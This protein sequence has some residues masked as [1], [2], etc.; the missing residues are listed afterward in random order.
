MFDSVEF[1]L[2]GRLYSYDT[3]HRKN[4]QWSNINQLT[5]KKIGRGNNRPKALGNDD[6]MNIDIGIGKRKERARITVYTLFVS[7]IVHLELPFTRLRP[8]LNTC[9]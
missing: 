4:G 3:C 7:F 6:D 9:T 2:K 1:I 5:I 8:I